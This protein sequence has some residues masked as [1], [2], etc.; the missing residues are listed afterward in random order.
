MEN[1]PYAY[2]LPTLMI[3]ARRAGFE[4]ECPHMEVLEGQFGIP[5]LA[6]MPDEQ[7]V[8]AV[9]RS[10]AKK[11]IFIN[12]PGPHSEDR[13]RLLRTGKVPFPGPL[14]CG[15]TSQVQITVEYICALPKRMGNTFYDYSSPP[16]RSIRERLC[17]SHPRNFCLRANIIRALSRSLLRIRY[18]DFVNQGTRYGL[19][20]YFSL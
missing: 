1:S 12:R 7:K 11:R 14:V 10:K 19:Q 20:P 8:R 16:A 18:R 17:C 5:S 2:R 6:L 13:A 15:A 4:D 9:C 3:L